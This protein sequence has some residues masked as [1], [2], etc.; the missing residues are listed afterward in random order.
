MSTMPA[1]ESTPTK[2]S[3]KDFLTDQEVRWCPGCG[4]Y[5]VLNAGT[6]A[7]SQLGVPRE[8]FV[9]VSGI[10]CSSRFPY[11]VN[12]Y[13]FH[14]IHGRAPAIATGVALANPELLVWVV[15]GDGDG[16]SIGGNHLIHA[17]R[18]NVNLKIILFDNRIYGLTKGQYSPTSELGKINKSAPFG[19]VEQ[20]LDPISLALACGATF[21]ARSV[22]VYQKHLVDILRR[23]A[24]HKG[25]AFIHVYQNCN[26]YNDNA[27]AHFTDKDVRDDC[28]LELV[29]GKPL[30][31]GKN[32][33]KGIRVTRDHQVEVVPLGNGG[34]E[35]DLL[36]YN[37]NDIPTAH[38]LAH[39]APPK[40]PM[41]I[42]V[43]REVH[44]PTYEAMVHQQIDAVTAKRGAGDLEK[45]YHSGETWDVRPSSDPRI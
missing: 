27:F 16:L 2:Y 34:S 8:K 33:D 1:P 37:S 22:D 30:V 39:L 44:M 9:I 28:N 31:F 13:G 26:V 19:T 45:L 40:Y 20:P 38:L 23:A 43:F 32:K 17:M 29:H 15:T 18:R 7:F 24:A 41:P 14:G 25:C 6:T 42:G 36:V 10:G 5:S 4:D 35:S 3:R 21:V 11:Y 12:T